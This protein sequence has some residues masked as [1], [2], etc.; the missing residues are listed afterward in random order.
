[1]SNYPFICNTRLTG[2]LTRNGLTDL[3]CLLVQRQEHR[4]LHL[5]KLRKPTLPDLWP[6]ISGDNGGD[7]PQ[8][9]GLSRTLINS[10]SRANNQTRQ[11]RNHHHH[12][13]GAS[14]PAQ[15]PPTHSPNRRPAQSPESISSS[16]CGTEQHSPNRENKTYD[17][18][19]LR[20][21]MD[22][23]KCLFSNRSCHCLFFS[24]Y[25]LCRRECTKNCS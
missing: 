11:D 20:Q 14:S 24:H 9:P 8:L 1:M 23:E 21:Q 13:S 4:L 25:H 17:E 18:K 3:F 5:P 15:P 12:P 6:D 2:F 16:R 10:L 22:D 7:I 19:T